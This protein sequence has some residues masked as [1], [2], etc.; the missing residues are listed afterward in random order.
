MDWLNELEA[1]FYDEGIVKLAQCV[2]EC[3]DHNEDYIEK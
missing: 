1:N 3:L 2:D